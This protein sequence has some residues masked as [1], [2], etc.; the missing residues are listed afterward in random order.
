MLATEVQAFCAGEGI[1][2]QEMTAFVNL[3]DGGTANAKER[4]IGLA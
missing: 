3:A 4:G 1:K 2:H